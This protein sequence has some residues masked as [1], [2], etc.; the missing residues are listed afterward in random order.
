M[1]GN[2]PPFVI[3]PGG[4]GITGSPATGWNVLK[5]AQVGGLETIM[6]WGLQAVSGDAPTGSLTLQ[7]TTSSNNQFSPFFVG[8]GDST[9]AGLSFRGRSTTDSGTLPIF[10]FDARIGASSSVVNRNL[11]E[12]N[13]NGTPRVWINPIGGV[14]FSNGATAYANVQNAS[15]YG[16]SSSGPGG[17][18]GNLVLEPRNNGASCDVLIVGSGGA[19]THTFRNGGGVDHAGC[20]RT[21]GTSTPS[22]GSGVEIRYGGAAADVGDIICYN[23]TGAAYR[24]FRIG[25]L[26]VAIQAN[27]TSQL[28]VDSSVVTSNLPVQLKSYT[29]ATLPGSVVAGRII[30]V[31][32]AAGSPC[33][34]VSNGTNWKRC[35]DM[36]VTVT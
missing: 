14:N 5:T 36:T 25:G 22:S 28:T 34:A 17:L 23:R 29:V 18:N 27:G 16:T 35:D 12:I 31:S 11:M 20:I 1:F 15:V 32:D 2:I 8:V 13:N 33:M 9:L 4:F 7:N 24:D 6:T 10:Y 21:T 19:I 3:Q 30:Y 26:T